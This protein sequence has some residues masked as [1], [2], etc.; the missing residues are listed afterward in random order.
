MVLKREVQMVKIKLCVIQ[1]LSMIDS[2][3]PTLPLYNI[4]DL[5]CA[6]RKL[7][8]SHLWTKV[9]IADIDQIVKRL[10]ETTYII[11]YRKRRI[12]W[13]VIK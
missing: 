4:S 1:A 6:F 10:H 9:D 12:V 5:I 13:Q 7:L 2:V 11:I 8:C 3:K